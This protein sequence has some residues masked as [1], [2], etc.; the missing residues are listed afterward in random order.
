MSRADR[1]RWDRRYADPSGSL[2]QEPHAL[3]VRYAPPCQPGFRALELACGLGRDA[4]WLGRQGCRVDAVDISF[5]ALRQAHAEKLRQKI[6]GVHFILADLDHFPLPDLTYDLVYVFR[7][8]DRKLFPAIRDRVRPGGLVIYET[9]NRRW[10]DA[11]PDTDPDHMLEIGELPG[12]FPGWTV[13]AASDE[14]FLSGLVA[15]K[16]SNTARQKLTEGSS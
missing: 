16:P 10:L 3:L 13:I 1:E 2:K 9:I 8:L 14:G 11:H 12:H 15:K 4:L 6:D 7:F 5:T